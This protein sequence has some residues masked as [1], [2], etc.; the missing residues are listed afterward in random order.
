MSRIIGKLTSEI[1]GKRRISRR[2][3]LNNCAREQG[4]A[5][6]PVKAMPSVLYSRKGHSLT[7]AGR[8]RGD[9]G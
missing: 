2:M 1:R 9:L 5:R 3:L 8:R 4:K 6:L 7:E